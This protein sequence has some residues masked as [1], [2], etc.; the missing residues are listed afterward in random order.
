[1]AQAVFVSSDLMFTSRLQSAATE[2]GTSLQTIALASGLK[3][4]LSPDCQVV[5]IDLSMDNLD[6]PAAIATIRSAA[7]QARTVAFGAHVN[8]SALAAAGDAGCDLVLSRGQ[9]HKQYIELLRSAASS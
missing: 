6:L 2:V 5:L 9:F 8:E 1:V 3:S 7:P 4:Q